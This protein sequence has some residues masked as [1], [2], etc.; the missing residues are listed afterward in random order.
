MISG[1]QRQRFMIAMSILRKPNI[2]I[3][4]DS[5]SE[6]DDAD[7]KPKHVSI[8]ISEP[9]EILTQTGNIITSE[10][11]EPEPVIDIS[12]NAITNTINDIISD[13]SNNSN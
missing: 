13:I 3:A 6:D 4:D 5:S 12:E 11:E 10:I 9:G 2:L 8:N 7:E 1:G